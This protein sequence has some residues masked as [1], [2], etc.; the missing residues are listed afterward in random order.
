MVSQ[1]W[2]LAT[3][4]LVYFFLLLP[5]MGG[6]ISLKQRHYRRWIVENSLMLLLVILLI[7]ERQPKPRRD[8]LVM[9]LGKVYK[10]RRVLRLHRKRVYV[11]WGRR[12]D[13]VILSSPTTDLSDSL[14]LISRAWDSNQNGYSGQGQGSGIGSIAKRRTGN[15]FFISQPPTTTP[16]PPLLNFNSPSPLLSIACDWSRNIPPGCGCN[17]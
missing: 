9:E 4:K 17:E 5:E 13:G 11:Q 12:P 3:N 8:W 14:P 16:P 1:A 2:Y 7:V 15:F 10:L 6:Q